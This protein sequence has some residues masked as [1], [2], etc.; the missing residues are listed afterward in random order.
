MLLN[1]GE[2]QS[3]DRL[4]EGKTTIGLKQCSGVLGRKEMLKVSKKT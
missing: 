1:G 3:E 4:D 2:I